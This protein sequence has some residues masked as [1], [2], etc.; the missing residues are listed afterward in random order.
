MRYTIDLSIWGGESLNGIAPF[1]FAGARSRLYMGE[2]MTECILML[3][4]DSLYTFT[5]L[6]CIVIDHKYYP[7]FLIRSQDS[8]LSLA[9][10]LHILD[11][12][13]RARQR[14]C[15]EPSS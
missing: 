2:V 15:T 14:D 9:I 12:H 11:D 3:F 4:V 13:T 10:A 1:N 7:T 8:P 6:Y 5:H